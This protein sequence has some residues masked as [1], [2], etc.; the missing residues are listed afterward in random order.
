MQK[1]NILYIDANIY[2][3]F[4]NSNISEFK[5]LLSTI[6]ELSDKIFFTQQFAYEIDRNKLNVFRQSIENY[7]KQAS[8]TKTFLPEHLHEGNLSKLKVWNNE[9]KKL[10]KSITESNS[11]LVKILSEILQNISISKDNVSNALLTLYEKSKKPSSDEIR[12]AQLRK[13]L[14]N[15]PGKRMDPLG[16]QLS[17]E[18]LLS[19][20][21]K[22]NSI[23]I[24]SKDSDYYTEYNNTLYLNSFLAN[25]LRSLNPKIEIKVFNKL[26]EALKE[27]NKLEKIVSIPTN[28]ELDIIAINE[29]FEESLVNNNPNMFDFYFSAGK[30]ISE[31]EKYDIRLLKL[32]S[33]G[34]NL[35]DISRQFKIEDMEPN[36]LSAIEKCINKLKIRFRVANNIQLIYQASQMGLIS[37]F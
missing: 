15:P 8:I 29:N 13:E 16:D 11:E 33:Q 12:N 31:L 17:W 14:G 18:M 24:I 4:Y 10:E 28:D 9:R 36:T 2:L 22:V 37:E 19:N 20:I 7:I 1:T 25:D 35:Q 32:L 27:Y 23:W 3:G 30:H 5:K 34:F 21:P 6:Q 26:A